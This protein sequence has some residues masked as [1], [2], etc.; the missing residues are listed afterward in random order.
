MSDKVIHILIIYIFISLYSLQFEAGGGKLSKS[1]QSYFTF[2]FGVKEQYISDK[3]CPEV[4]L[5]G[6]IH[7]WLKKTFSNS[8]NQ[9]QAQSHLKLQ[10]GFYEFIIFVS[11]IHKQIKIRSYCVN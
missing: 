7:S 11:F 4:L 9:I 1:I 5:S 3:L 6:K 10:T 8:N 2:T